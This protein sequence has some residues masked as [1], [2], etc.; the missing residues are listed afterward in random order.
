MKTNTLTVLLVITF[1]LLA[2][3]GGF[4]LGQSNATPS[5]P[6]AVEANVP[7]AA[8]ETVAPFWEVW[9]LIHSRYFDQPLD[10]TSLTEGAINGMLAVHGDP[11]TTYLSPDVEAGARDGIS[12]EFQGIGVEVEMVDGEIVVIS[13]IDGS[14]A[15][16]A[17]LLP[18]DI[19]RRADGVDLSDKGIQEVV[20]LV[21]GPAGTAIKLLIER[22]EQ[23]F[24]ADI[25]RAVIRSAQARGEMLDEGIA[26]VRLS[27]FG[28]RTKDELEETLTA[29]MAKDP[30]GL[31]LDLRRNPGGLLET[32]VDIA[33][34]FLPSGTVLL[35]QFGNGQEDIF[36]ASEDGLAQELPM[37]V[38]VDRGSASASEVLASALRDQERGVLVGER[39]FGKG[40]M[41]TWQSLSNGG[42]VRITFAR[43]LTPNGEWVHEV[44]LIPDYLIPSAEVENADEYV[45]TQLQAAIDILLGKTVTSIPEGGEERRHRDD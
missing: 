43:W 11:N 21:R 44:G 10:D 29:L 17:G 41:Q 2:F 14:P 30:I 42:G 16:V 15:A 31:I 28:D 32:V 19:L 39:T 33:D 13:P 35:Q 5:A 37:V 9:E 40:T 6:V 7:E 36:E 25:I 26:Y 20:A 34:Q 12:G 38:L 22:D 3:G 1:I 18:G 24:E 8:N 45:D 27:R 23:M 4:A